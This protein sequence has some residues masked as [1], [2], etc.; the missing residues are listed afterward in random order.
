MCVLTTGEGQALRP[1][2]EGLI[3][4]YKDGGVTPPILLYTDRDCCGGGNI[5]VKLFPEWSQTQVR[6]DIWHFMR[7]LASCCTTEAHLLYPT[8][9]DRLPRCIFAWDERDLELLKRAKRSELVGSGKIDDPTDQQVLRC[10]TKRELQ[11]H[12]RRKT[13]GTAET[14]QLLE[15]TLG[16]FTGPGGIDMAGMPLLDVERTWVIWNSQKKHVSCLQDP[17]G[18]QLYTQVGTSNKGGVELPIYRCA[19]GTTSLESFHLHL[20]RFIPGVLFWLF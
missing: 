18:V 17:E 3:K 1:M 2:A 15:E 8:F 11:I 9:M 6:L 7:R 13:R 12:C 16:F 5:G 14:T 4:R 20:N 10:L 19:R